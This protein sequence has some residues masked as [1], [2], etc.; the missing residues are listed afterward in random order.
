MQDSQD[1]LRVRVLLCFLKDHACTVT[2]IARD[3]GG[4][5]NIRSAGC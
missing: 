3:A 4:R 1:I 5:R 2:S